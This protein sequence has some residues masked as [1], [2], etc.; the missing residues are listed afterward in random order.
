MEYV[1][2]SITAPQGRIGNADKAK[3]KIRI[4]VKLA[5]NSLATVSGG[6]ERRH[7]HSAQPDSNEQYKKLLEKVGQI[8]QG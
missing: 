6:L 7:D 8:L 4:A 1:F 2:E 3:E 5:K